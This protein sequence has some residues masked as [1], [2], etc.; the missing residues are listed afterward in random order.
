MGVAFDG[1]LFPS[2]TILITD[3][4]SPK[5]FTVATI[6]GKDDIF[7]EEATR[8]A[9]KKQIRSYRI[10]AGG[11]LLGAAVTWKE[12]GTY[13]AESVPLAEAEAGYREQL[14]FWIQHYRANRKKP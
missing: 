13:I 3:S 8:T 1:E 6:P 4:G 5:L 2:K 10:S 12:N 14:A 11:K 9:G 7:I